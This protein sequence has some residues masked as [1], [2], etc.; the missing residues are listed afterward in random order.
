MGPLLYKGQQNIASGKTNRQSHQQDLTLGAG[1][2]S[3]SKTQTSG[4]MQRAATPPE[5]RCVA[6]VL[7]RC[8][9]GYLEEWSDEGK[10]E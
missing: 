3:T 1:G 8:Y 10:M 6:T 5:G 9:S 2:A 7:R 4:R